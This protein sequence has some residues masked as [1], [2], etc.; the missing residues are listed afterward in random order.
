MNE[1]SFID[2]VHRLL[3]AEPLLKWKI[4][5]PYTGGKPDCYYC[6]P[7][8][9]L[10]IEYKFVQLPK[11]ASTR[12]QI[13]LSALQADWLSHLDLCGQTAWVVV[14]SPK[15][16]VVLSIQEALSGL[17]KAQYEARMIT[18]KDLAS[19]IKDHCGV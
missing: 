13:D 4:N 11:R 16:A 10:W 7:S 8:D 6:G 3:P 19:R 12:V 2:A 18:F 17:T 15:R 1:H 5:D 14:G 9:D